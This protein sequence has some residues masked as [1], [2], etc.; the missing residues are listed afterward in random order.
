MPNLYIM[1]G[2]PAAGKD[3]LSKQMIE[4][5][6]NI[7]MHSSDSIRAEL[8]G[9]ESIQGDPNKIFTLMVRR[10]IEDLECG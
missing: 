10:T 3:V 1:I 8:Y 7:V 6:E 5:H 9:D 4:N 2:L